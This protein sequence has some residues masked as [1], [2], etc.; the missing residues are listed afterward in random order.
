M[1]L[2]PPPGLEVSQLIGFLEG[3]CVSLPLTPGLQEIL[4]SVFSCTFGCTWINKAYPTLSVCKKCLNF[5]L[6]L[7]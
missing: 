6:S 2:V 3:S 1:L 4:R 7:T 5:E